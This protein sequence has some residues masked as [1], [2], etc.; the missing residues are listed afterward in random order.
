MTLSTAH[1]GSRGG[2]RG[3]WGAVVTFSTAHGGSRGG[4]R[5][6]GLWGAVV[7]LSTA[8]RGSRGGSWG[9][10]GA[11]SRKQWEGNEKYKVATRATLMTENLFDCF[12]CGGTA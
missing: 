2:S 1:G 4:S 3:L 6:G 11:V 8:H 7:T 10:W 5:G 9:L 12:V